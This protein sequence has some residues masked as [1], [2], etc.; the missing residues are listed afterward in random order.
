M[1]SKLRNFRFCK[2]TTLSNT[3][4]IAIDVGNTL[5]KVGLFQHDQLK[6]YYQTE[7]QA[8]GV[9]LE[10]ILE[11]SQPEAAIVSAVG[12]QDANLEVFFK[13]I[14]WLNLHAQTPVP[15]TNQYATPETLG[16]DRVAVMAAAAVEYPQQN[17]LVIDA[18]TCITYDFMRADAVYLG[19]AIAPGLQMRYK[20]MHTQT[21]GLPLLK[22]EDPETFLGTSTASSMHVG[23]VQGVLAE[24]EGM[25]SKYDVNYD[26]LTV[27]LTG[28]DAPFLAERLKNTIFAIPNFLLIGMNH[29]LEY[30][31]NQ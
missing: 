31:K 22:L 23:V 18:G 24:I 26:D 5:V 10:E 11:N 28:G 7:R 1:Q 13:E 9:L 15:F 27:I 14:Y 6:E 21:A 17:V 29:I 30:N 25:I 20:A 3:M 4:N 19:G 16:V 8:L 12:H 2:F